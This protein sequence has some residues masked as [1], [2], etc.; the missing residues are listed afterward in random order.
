[1][2]SDRLWNNSGQALSEYALL[3]AILVMFLLVF[4]ERGSSLN[5][6]NAISKYQEGI[7]FLVDLPVP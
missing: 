6:F 7:I 5:I 2:N 4:F 1:M 3:C